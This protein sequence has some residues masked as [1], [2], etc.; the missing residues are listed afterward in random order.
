MAGRLRFDR[1]VYDNERGHA[2]VYLLNRWAW[3]VLCSRH[4]AAEACKVQKQVF[5]SLVTG[6]ESAGRLY[7][8]P[9]GYDLG[10]RAPAHGREVVSG[11]SVGVPALAG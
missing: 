1:L 10:S 8:A 7:T 4:S 6:D 9:V 3:G 5:A 11:G 2:G